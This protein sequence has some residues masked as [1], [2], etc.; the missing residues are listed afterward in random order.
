MPTEASINT[1]LDR[2]AVVF[3]TSLMLTQVVVYPP[4]EQADE[5]FDENTGEWTDA[6]LTP[7]YTGKAYI[8]MGQARPIKT[9][10]LGEALNAI[11]EWR[12]L[13]PR[14][15]V[16]F[17]P[18]SVVEITDADRTPQMIGQRFRVD[19]W[20]ENTLAPTPRYMITAYHPRDHRVP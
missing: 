13:V 19:D 17:P 16:T 12:F 15:T 3:E 11:R 7:L 4:R 1:A 2:A 10:E 18:G 20:P 6:P 8:R 14:G 9:V 5:F